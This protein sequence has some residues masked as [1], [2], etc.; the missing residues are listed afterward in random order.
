MRLKQIRL[1]QNLLQKDVANYLNRTIAA[2]CDWERG[3]TEPCIDDLIKLAE[4][5]NVSVDYLLGVSDDMGNVVNNNLSET[6]NYIVNKIRLLDSQKKQELVSFVNY[7]A[8]K[9]KI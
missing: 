1:A 8:S 9:D 7:L 4:L 2:I 5:F 6:E 3:R